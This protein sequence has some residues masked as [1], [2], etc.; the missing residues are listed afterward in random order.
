[1]SDLSSVVAVYPSHL[2]AGSAIKELR[3]AQAMALPA[4]PDLAVPAG[5]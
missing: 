4:P 3:T 2:E 1:M 5:K